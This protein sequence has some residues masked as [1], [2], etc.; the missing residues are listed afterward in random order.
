MTNRVYNAI[1]AAITDYG[2]AITLQSQENARHYLIGL[3]R[4]LYEAD[5]ITY[6]EK[7]SFYQVINKEGI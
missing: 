7:E 5:A 2:R 1:N 4:G 3:L 6:E